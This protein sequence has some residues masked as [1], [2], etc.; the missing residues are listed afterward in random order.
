MAELLTLTL[1]L[2][3]GLAAGFLTLAVAQRA[4]SPA[5]TARARLYSMGGRPVVAAQPSGQQYLRTPRLS[6]LPLLEMLLSRNQWARTAALELDRAD[7]PLKVSEYIMLRLVAAVLLFLLVGVMAG[8][9]RVGL[10]GLP[11][12]YLL[13][14]VYMARRQRSR[15]Q[16]V[17]KQLAEAVVLIST[18]LKAGSSLLQSVELA[19]RRMGLPIAR[20]LRRVIRDINVGASV[21]EAMTNLAAR[22]QSYDMD[23]VV[24]AV[25]IQRTVGGN[26]AEIL[27]TVAHTMRE[28]ERVR[29]ELRALTAQQR[30]SGIVVVILP[31][32]VA[33]IFYVLDP[34]YLEPLVTTAAG[35]V[36]LGGAAAAQIFAAVLIKRILSIEL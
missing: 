36:M 18:S 5:S 10:V 9:M 21:E 12:G 23:I 32:A 25:L 27:D 2:A 13:P 14:R 11:I 8:D 15:R 20:E 30:L 35:R 22:V 29:G 24:N 3:V 16:Q 17:N 31:L 28:R 7:L 26:L 19:G 1:P 34:E 33:G 4:P 6:N